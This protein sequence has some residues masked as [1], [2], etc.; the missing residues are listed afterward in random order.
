MA[1]DRPVRLVPEGELR[2]SA[3]FILYEA[4]NFFAIRS[5]GHA[6]SL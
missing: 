5:F 4:K 3:I 6:L 2:L 1:E